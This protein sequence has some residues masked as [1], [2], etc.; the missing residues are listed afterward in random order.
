MGLYER[1]PGSGIWYVRFADETGKIV[2]KK[3]GPKG[4]AG[5]V[6]VQSRANVDRIRA[7]QAAG[8]DVEE[9][10]PPARLTVRDLAERYRVETQTNC[11]NW[12]KF[13]YYDRLWCAHMGDKFIDQVKAS[14]VEAYKGRRISEAAPATVNKEIRRLQRLFNLAIRDDLAAS[15]PVARVRKL[16]EPPARVRYLTADEELRLRA[17]IGEDL[18]PI[19]EFAFRTGCRQE[20]QFTIRR[21]DL[22]LNQGNLTLKKTKNRKGQQ[23]P[24][25]PRVRQLLRD[26]IATCPD[27]PWLFPSVAKPSSHWSAHN[28]YARVFRPAVELAGIENFVWHDLRHT[29]ASRLVM[30]GADLRTVQEL[31]GHASITQTMLYAHLAPGRAL[32]ATSLLD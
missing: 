6:L 2:R 24:L 1:P 5:K 7:M 11:A 26:W 27:S 9:D 16:S 29:F 20:S 4:L 3:V 17:E 12:K 14:D 13:F 10:S 22:D 28:F 25:S 8:L 19:V 21:A 30:A 18:W 31:M 23:V 32:E 15:N